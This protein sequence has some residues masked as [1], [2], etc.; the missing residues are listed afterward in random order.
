MIRKH[1]AKPGVT[2]A[3][4]LRD[5]AKATFPGGEKTINPGLLQVFLKQ[6][7]ALVEN[8]AIVFYAA[9]VFFEKLRIKNGE[10]KDDLRLTME[11]I[12]PFGI[13]REKPV[14]GPWIVATGSQPYINEFGQLRVL[15]NCY[16]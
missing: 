6:E 11:E 13:E 10:P 14:N 15:R 8:T 4:F 16:P 3:G 12:W 9:Y 2:K 5:A 7:G 1:V